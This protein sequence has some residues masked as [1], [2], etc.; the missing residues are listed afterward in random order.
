M[1]ANFQHLKLLQFKED[2]IN[3]EERTVYGYA[4]TPAVDRYD[5]IVLPAAFG[6]SLQ[7]YLSNPVIYWNHQWDQVPIGRCAN[8]LIKEE[9]LYVGVKFGTTPKAEE[10]WTA[11]TVD[12]SVRSMSI[13]FNGEYSPEW[14]YW[15]EKQ[16]VWVWQKVD[17][18]E[19]SVCG[20]PANPEA[21]FQLSKNLGLDC[22]R[23]TP[24]LPFADL[25]IGAADVMWFDDAAEREI[26]KWAG[27]DPAKLAKCYLYRNGDQYALPI[28]NIVDNAP[29][30]QWDAVAAQT[31]RVLGARGTR[32]GVD[33]P[34]SARASV[35]GH[36]KQYYEKFEKT[37]PELPPTG[38]PE[39]VHQANFFSQELDSLER[40][41]AFENGQRVKWGAEANAKIV[42]HWLKSQ[43]VPSQG[44]VD[45]SV[46][47]ITDL[48]TVIKSGKVLS[49]ANRSDIEGAIDAL[50]GVLARDDKA[51]DD[52]KSDKSTGLV[53]PTK[54]DYSA[55]L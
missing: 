26:R 20:M 11:V 32:G 25:A 23:F 34:Q 54:V 48:A 47:S 17:L 16:Q 33:L 4:S 28:A 36:L 13:G 7:H 39:D 49:A 29:V 5:E 14:G 12:K 9:G 15:D 10:V 8:A 21:T 53:F 27:D 43:G 35:F 31:A 24:A 2:Q 46:S 55:L 41:I 44:L 30:V 50:Q 45:L 22:T 51:K 3:V 38:W 1:K 18:R 40:S 6:F 37:P 42:A 52:E 19:I